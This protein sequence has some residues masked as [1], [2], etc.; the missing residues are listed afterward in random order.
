LQKSEFNSVKKDIIL[1]SG[2][3]LSF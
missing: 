3:F 2:K 1:K